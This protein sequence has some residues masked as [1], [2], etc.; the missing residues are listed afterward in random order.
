MKTSP[1]LERCDPW[2]Q[3]A[4]GPFQD[5]PMAWGWRHEQK[6]AGLLGQVQRSEARKQIVGISGN[7]GRNPRKA[8]RI[9]RESLSL[10][11]PGWSS[12][13]VCAGPGSRKP[14]E[15]PP[16]E[17]R[18]PEQAEIPTC[19]QCWE[20][21]VCSLCYKSEALVRHW[22]LLSKPLC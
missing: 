8:G 5:C 16:L 13:C 21:Q 2:K 15:K 7:L 10:Q 14:R 6:G 12:K 20:D 22:G 1:K 3:G 9:V 11:V 19:G 17:G 18:R 4:T